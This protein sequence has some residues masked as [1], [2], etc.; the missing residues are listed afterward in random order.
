[1]ISNVGENMEVFEPLIIAGRNVKWYSLRERIL[2][3]L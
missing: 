1:M 2:A 3:V